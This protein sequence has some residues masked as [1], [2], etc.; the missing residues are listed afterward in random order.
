MKNVLLVL[1]ILVGHSLFATTNIGTLDGRPS[2]TLNQLLVGGVVF[3]S[4]DVTTDKYG[5]IYVTGYTNVDTIAY[6][7]F[8]T[9]LGGTQDAYIAKL[10][11]DGQLVWSTYFG[12]LNY[13]AGSGITVDDSGNVYVV[14]YTQSINNIP[15]PGAFNT[16]GGGSFLL[17]L[18]ANGQ[19]LWSTYTNC[20]GYEGAITIDGHGAIYVAGAYG[21]GAGI[22]TAGAYQSTVSNCAILKFNAAGQRIWGTYYGSA[23]TIYAI[24]ADK[25]NNIYIAGSTSGTTGYATAGAYQTSRSGLLD[26]FVAKF[27]S[28]GA[29]LWA[30]YVGTSQDD[31]ITCMAIDNND[32]LLLTGYSVSTTSSFDSTYK[33]IG[34]TGT[35]FPK[36]VTTNHSKNGIIL[37]F[38]KN[39]TRIWGTYYG[40]EWDDVLTG[41]GTDADQR[42]YV[43]GSSSSYTN[44]NINPLTTTT[45]SAAVAAKF[46]INGRIEWSTYLDTLTGGVMANYSNGNLVIIASYNVNRTQLY[47]IKIRNTLAYVKGRLIAD[48]NNN[49]VIDSTDIGIPQFI[50]KVEPGP[51]YACSDANGNYK[52]EVDTGHFNIS[53]IK[54]PA[55]GNAP[56]CIDSFPVALTL[57]NNSVD[58]V[59]FLIDSIQPESPLWVDLCTSLLRKCQTANYVISYRNEGIT[60]ANNAYVIIDPGQY[61]TILNA[62]IPWDSI[63]PDGRYRFPV[64]NLT[65]TSTHHFTIQV[66]VSCTAPLNATNCMRANIFSQLPLS[67]SPLNNI[68]QVALSGECLPSDSIKFT[69]T[70][71]NTIG[72]TQQGNYQIYVNSMLSQVQHFVVP[73]ADTTHIWIKA[74]GNTIRNELVF[75]V[76]GTEVRGWQ[77]SLEGCGNT[78][79]TG[80]IMQ[81]PQNDEPNY[82]E[83]DCQAILASHDPNDKLASP[84]G[85]T[86]AAYINAADALEYT[87]RF[88]NT[89]NDTAFLVVL[90]DTLSPLLDVTSIQPGVSSHPYQFSI[91]G[92]GVLQFT[93]N[94]IMLPDSNVDEEASNGYVKFKIKQKLGNPPLSVINNFAD[95]YFDYNLPVRTA[96]VTRTIFDTTLICMGPDTAFIAQPS[97][98]N[99]LEY[100]FI[101][102]NINSTTYYWNFG[103]STLSSNSQNPVHIYS[104][105][106]TYNVCMDVSNICRSNTICDSVLV[107]AQ[108][109]NIIPL[110]KNNAVNVYPN[111]YYN[112]TNIAFNVPSAGN[113][114]IQVVDIMGQ[115]VY[116]HNGYYPNVGMYNQSINTKQ[117]GIYTVKLT[118]GNN[119]NSQRIISIN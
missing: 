100:N 55:I 38:N 81:L 69:I 112:T 54:N 78:T 83:L 39:G 36:P 95:I 27:D 47:K 65:F 12:G 87:I 77:L 32:N 105:P 84:T 89:G 59:N 85:L 57:V 114:L 102:S 4:K 110:D 52:L 16:T 24:K 14:G 88:Q 64:G 21:S 58:S 106:G 113:V 41:I 7:G 30:T 29:R 107:Q 20:G 15:T 2:I 60:P 109:T 67:Q 19:R 17:K 33:N 45:R 108:T 22:A 76:N 37:K 72:D 61:L 74:D 35:S 99:P 9:V 118:I 117:A 42:V 10:T 82:M 31:E 66:Q 116:E 104:A 26:G 94:D 1:C 73:P 86:N 93:F 40:G 43:C 3:L 71:T 34:T 18:D 111:P 92:N 75:D 103:D 6:G 8:Q 11:Q 63:Y 91:T 48:L 119:V 90:V 46:D 62:E 44:I 5:N 13:D 49:C 70:N 115:I 50:I 98:S 101:T 97:S 23:G 25:D 51:Y 96:T 56:M 28:L 80:D 79:H 53:V 68:Y